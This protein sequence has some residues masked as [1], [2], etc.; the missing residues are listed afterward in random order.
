MGTGIDG[1]TRLQIRE[2]GGE[3][4]QIFA[5]ISGGGGHCFSVEIS[6]VYTIVGFIAFS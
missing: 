1:H 4:T 5:K 2:G 6:R 3:R